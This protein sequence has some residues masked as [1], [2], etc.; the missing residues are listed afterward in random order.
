MTSNL[1]LSKE[2]SKM[3]NVVGILIP[4]R[5]RELD[6]MWRY[7]SNRKLQSAITRAS[8]LRMALALSPNQTHNERCGTQLPSCPFRMMP[9]GR[10]MDGTIPYCLKLE[11]GRRE[12][13]CHILS[14]CERGLEVWRRI[15]AWKRRSGRL[16]SRK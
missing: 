7:A 11:E 12:C 16:S 2:G 9:S 15:Q 5:Y 3:T 1:S 4:W 13:G 14:Y 10:E 6:G 8:V